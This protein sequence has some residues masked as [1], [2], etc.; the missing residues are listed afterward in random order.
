MLPLPENLAVLLG[1]RRAVRVR[2]N[3]ESI[4]P[5]VIDQLIARECIANEIAEMTPP[6]IEYLAALLFLLNSAPEYEI[7]RAALLALKEIGLRNEQLIDRLVIPI[8]AMTLFDENDMMR[9]KALEELPQI[10]LDTAQAVSQLLV[11]D[12]NA[13]IARY[14]SELIQLG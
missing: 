12:T 1:L 4:V 3:D 14:A 9:G 11:N 7:Q 5:D 8:A 2:E 13:G 10:D 6:P